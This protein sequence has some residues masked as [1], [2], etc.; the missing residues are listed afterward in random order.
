MLRA[1]S[2]G[3]S[4]PTIGR[5]LAHRKVQ[6]TACY[7]HLVRSLV[8]VAAERLSDSVVADPDSVPDGGSN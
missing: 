8:D 4:L 7:A 3:G 6:I 2:P 5:L 1:F